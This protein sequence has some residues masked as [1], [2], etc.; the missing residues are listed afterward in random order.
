MRILVLQNALVEKL[1]FNDLPKEIRDQ[2]FA[3]G[4]SANEVDKLMK[5]EVKNS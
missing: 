1:C 3:N 5:K 2:A 4:V